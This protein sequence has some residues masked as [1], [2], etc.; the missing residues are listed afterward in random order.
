MFCAYSVL[1]N[2][3]DCADEHDCFSK[4][5]DISLIDNL[6]RDSEQFLD[7]QE[8]NRVKF[9]PHAYMYIWD[10]IEQNFISQLISNKCT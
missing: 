5:Y 3:Y 10:H 4:L 2:L 8:N 9:F 1:S 6:S 7:N